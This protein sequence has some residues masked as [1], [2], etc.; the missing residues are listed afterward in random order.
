[1]VIFG[2]P[3]GKCR[4]YQQWK[5]ANIP[6]QVVIEILS[7]S[8]K[9]AEGEIAMDQKFRFYERYGVEEYY[10]YDP[11]EFTLEGWLRQ[12]QYLTPIHDMSH[13]ISP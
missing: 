1:M 2:R 7:A 11:D 8:N 3:K 12:G 9:T 10:I 13:W 5:E 4:S 6:P